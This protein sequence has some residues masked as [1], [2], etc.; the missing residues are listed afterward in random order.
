MRPNKT[1]IKNPEFLFIKNNQCEKFS[2]KGKRALPKDGSSFH[3][4]R[5]PFRYE[6]VEMN[7]THF[8]E[9]SGCS[10]F[11]FESFKRCLFTLF[12]P[13]FDLLW[14]QHE[15]YWCWCCTAWNVHQSFLSFSV[16]LSHFFHILGTLCGFWIRMEYLCAVELN[17]CRKTIS[18]I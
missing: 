13:F 5:S 3:N 17:D 18:I 4:R 14:K 1:K 12:W 7:R 10:L 9:H 2:A 8:S 6:K 11:H 16:F 15:T